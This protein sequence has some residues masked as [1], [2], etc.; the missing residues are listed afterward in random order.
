MKR[1]L[2]NA[3]QP[4]ELR[5]ALVDG[6]WLYDLDIENRNR[7]QKKANIYKGKI[8]RIEPS[9]EAAFVDYG[10]ERHGFL[11]LKEISRE[12]FMKQPRDIEGR[13]KIKDVIKEGMQIIVQVDKEERG[14]KGAALTTFIS[15]A[16]RYLVLMPN[17]PRAGGISRRIDGDDRADLRDA[18]GKIEVPSGMGAIVRTAGVGRSAE[19]L[20]WDLNYLLQLWDSIKSESENAPAPH[21][22]FQESNVIIRAIRDYLR[23]DIGE[24]IVDSPEAYELA[25]AFVQQVMPN[26][27]SKV[28]HYSDDTPLF[29]RYQ[30]ESQI[31]TAFER[32]V[33]LPSGG[34]IV[35]DVT[36]AL[37]SIDINSS[38]AT[39]GSDIEETALQTNLEAADEI[40]RQLRLRDIGGLQV[41]DFIDMQ[42]SRNQREVEN[43]MR[44]ALSMDRARVQVGRISRFGL[45]EMSRQRLRPSLGETTSKVCP[46]CSGQGTIR[47]TKS[48]ALSILRLVEEEAQKERS[49]EIRAIAPV[50]VATYLLNEKRKTISG[51]ETRNGTRVVIVPNAEMV[52]PHFE[53]QRLRD[54][55]TA[56]LETSYKITAAT[57]DSVQEE[58]PKKAEAPALQQPA[59]QQIV[60]AQ[61]APEPPKQPGLLSRLVKALEDLFT[62][63]P[64]PQPSRTKQNQQGRGKGGRNN[65]RG[66]NQQQNR[67]RNRR[68]NRGERDDRGERDNREGR[69]NRGGGQ[70]RDE[71]ARKGRRRDERGGRQD[72]N[73]RQEQAPKTA[74]AREST[75]PD[76][77]K[78]DQQRPAKRPANKRARPQQRRRGRRDAEAADT[79]KAAGEQTAESAAAAEQSP[80]T[81]NRDERH[82]GKAQR[83]EKRRQPKAEPATATA[84]E[85]QSGDAA[86]QPEATTAPVVASAKMETEK[87][88]A[89]T[90]PQEPADT[91]STATVPPA[92]EA[93]AAPVP[94]A[95]AGKPAAT[96]QAPGAGA[97]TAD[98]TAQVPEAEAE[99]PAA[100]AQLSDA[101]AETTAATAAVRNPEAETAATPVPVTEAETAP[102]SDTAAAATAETAPAAAEDKTAALQKESSPPRVKAEAEPALDTSSQ[103]SQ[104]TA[105][106]AEP[107]P[108]ETATQSQAP[109]DT[110]AAAAEVAPAPARAGNDPRLNPKPVTEVEITTAPQRD[111][112]GGPLDTAQPSKVEHRP[113]RLSRPANDPRV[114]RTT[115]DT[116][117]QA[118]EADQ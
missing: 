54:D 47:S 38:R 97:E 117:A 37:V 31:E 25:R 35:I 86:T 19:E 68:D 55:D 74:E 23:P 1:M 6:Q 72:D 79:A 115:G 106:A 83:A 44:E 42:P 91:A 33:K 100:T 50:P 95:E 30:I 2:I 56:T 105:A 77:D 58:K 84:A 76:Q 60:P 39:K 62:S 4:E 11:P 32:E 34:S 89:S 107:E 80:A 98:A 113:R 69:D 81:A 8:T 27:Q 94:E 61:P 17:N 14:N 57:D 85:K 7:E 15:L 63:E 75:Q 16:G 111:T 102:V 104:Q 93:T 78:S 46:R 12:Y 90:S 66:R 92:D 101:E 20:Q 70:R 88:G 53:V 26:F 103:T 5:V 22:L 87:P 49:A 13:L 99:T 48:L 51:I 114:N 40:A 3:T 29:N 18:L 109:V 118:R 67:N 43:R 10:S 73:R 28:K 45:L 71:Q 52:T 36:E 41:I 21:F 24:I 64:E 108:V 116:V 9:L 82:S 112:S 59:V 65:N 110:N 96:A